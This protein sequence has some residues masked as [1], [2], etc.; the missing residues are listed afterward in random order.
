MPHT[1]HT[2]M[3][4]DVKAPGLCPACDRYWAE[5]GPQDPWRPRADN[6]GNPIDAPD[7]SQAGAED[8]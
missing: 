2:H 7:D 3:T 5:Y 4:R 1:G 8:T 6:I